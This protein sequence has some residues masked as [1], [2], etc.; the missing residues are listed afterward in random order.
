[1]PID[2]RQL[3]R[4][5]QKSKREQLKKKIEEE[6]KDQNYEDRYNYDKQ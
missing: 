4:D 3:Y 1:M 2:T 5:V 6:S